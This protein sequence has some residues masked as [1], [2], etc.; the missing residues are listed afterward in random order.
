MELDMQQMLPLIIFGVIAALVFRMVGW[1][2][3]EALLNRRRHFVDRPVDVTA[4]LLKKLIKACRNNMRGIKVGRQLVCLG[5]A[6][7]WNFRWGR[8]VGVTSGKWNELLA[9]KT[10]RLT[11][12]RMILCSKEL[13]RDKNKR[14]LL[15]DCN[16]FR[17]VGPI[18]I[19]Q[20]TS[21]TSD[22]DIRRYLQ[23]IY[24]EWD[25]Q[26]QQEKIWENVENGAHAMKEALDIEK[27]NYRMMARQDYVPKAP[28]QEPG[29]EAYSEK[30]AST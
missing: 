30:Q 4:M 8:V 6:D 18:W 26:M 17:P 7:Y 23:L 13:L 9:V 19:P 29:G 16:G 27:E 25:W 3:I 28:G 5:E 11:P 24:K 20:F 15:A 22:E 12:A 21:T 1:P 14:Y 10:R 2:I